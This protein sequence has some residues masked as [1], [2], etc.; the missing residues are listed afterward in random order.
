MVFDIPAPIWGIIS[1]YPTEWK[2]I[3][4]EYFTISDD[5]GRSK[6]H[7]SVQAAL[8]SGSSL[9]GSAPTFA[10]ETSCFSCSK[11]GRRFGSNKSLLQHMRVAHGV[12]KSVG[13][14]VGDWRRCPICSTVFGSRMAL[15]QHLSETRLRS[16]HRCATCKDAFLAT[17]PPPIPLDVLKAFQ[18]TDRADRRSAR[19][20]GHTHALVPELAK[21]GSRG[22]RVTLCIPKPAIPR[23]LGST[24]ASR[25]V[26]PEVRLSVK[27]RPDIADASRYVP[28][29]RL[30]Q[31]TSFP[32]AQACLNA[33]KRVRLTQK[34]TAS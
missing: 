25:L 18:A 26:H 27:S 1:T 15:V 17:N 21:I 2:K 24:S 4:K 30:C 34:T 16:K 33:C 3:V 13:E 12:R 11:C 29:R 31:K 6:Y 23:C 10:L 7:S 22:K 19:R 32:S 14:L 8:P 9:A 20:Q 5:I 28:K